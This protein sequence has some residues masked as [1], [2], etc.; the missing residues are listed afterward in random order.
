[1][2]WLLFKT[3]LS[4]CALSARR[5]RLFT[6]VCYC[7][8][9][10]WW[11][12]YG[13]VKSRTFF[14]FDSTSAYRV[15]VIEMGL[16]GCSFRL[17]SSSSICKRL[18]VGNPWAT[19]SISFFVNL[20]GPHSVKIGDSVWGRVEGTLGCGRRRVFIVILGW[21]DWNNKWSLVHWLSLVTCAVLRNVCGCVG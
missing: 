21:R 7:C 12:G 14:T 11:W 5:F 9:R 15:F 20:H 19:D 1:M 18:D 17:L 13:V 10:C 8:Y 4:K 3:D 2:S 16:S 6:V